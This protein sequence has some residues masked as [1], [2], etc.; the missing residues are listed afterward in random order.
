[1]QS[2]KVRSSQRGA[3]TVEYSLLLT[4]ILLGLL[5]LTQDLGNL[6]HR[7]LRLVALALGGA[8]GT[9]NPGGPPFVGSVGEDDVISE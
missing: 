1:M 7:K 2:P 5:V 3:A 4:S 6:S 8:S 9:T